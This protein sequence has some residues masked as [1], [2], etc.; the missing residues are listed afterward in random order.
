M[1]YY[2][3][4]GYLPNQ[5]GYG[6]TMS[7]D[8]GSNGHNRTGRCDANHAAWR[9]ATGLEIADGYGQ[10]ET[11]HLVG[12]HVGAEIRPGSM[13]KPL[14]GVELR[15]ND[16]VLELRPD[17]CP[18]FFSRYLDAEPFGGEWWSTGDVVRSDDDG[19]LWYEG[20]DDDLI[21]SAGYRIGP[22]EVESALLTHPSVAEAAAVAAPDPE[23]GSVVRAIV[24]LR[25][26]N[27]SAE[28]ARELQEHVKGVTAPYKYP[29]IV[30]FAPELPKTASG[31]I[32]RAELRAD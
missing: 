5:N 2:I 31:Q 18:T 7:G 23:R 14:A 13:G 29:R 10:T 8:G 4:T 6:L 22:F 16:G 19:Y 1:M 26:G 32:K 27:G 21:L 30:E 11:G 12:N 24:V 9:D 20:R 3:C 17:T 15:L 28:L 25:E